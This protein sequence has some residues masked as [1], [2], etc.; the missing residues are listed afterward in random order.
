MMVT[1][2]NIPVP[3]PITPM[4]SAKIV[5]APMHIPPKVAAIGMYLFKTIFNPTLSL[6]PGMLIFSLFSYLSTSFTLLPLTSIQVFEN[7][8]QVP[9]TKTIYNIV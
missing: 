5:R 2:S 1:D 4:K 7:T 6:L 8:A 9:K 3:D